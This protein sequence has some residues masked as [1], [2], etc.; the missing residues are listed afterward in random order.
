MENENE[1]FAFLK[2]M[3]F[4]DLLDKIDKAHGYVGLLCGSNDDIYY[5][6]SSWIH[7]DVLM[8]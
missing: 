2:Y 1:I 6:I 7:L 5:T 8:V 3:G 4:T